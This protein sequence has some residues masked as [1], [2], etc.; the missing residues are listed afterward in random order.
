MFNDHIPA[1]KAHL[2]SQDRRILSIVR[3]NKFQSIAIGEPNKSLAKAHV[4]TFIDRDITGKRLSE[5]GM[6]AFLVS[7]GAAAPKCD[8]V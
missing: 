5:M 3:Q 2:K 4:A 8:G 1:H 6:E 7:A